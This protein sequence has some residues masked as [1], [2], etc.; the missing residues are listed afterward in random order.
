MNPLNCSLRLVVFGRTRKNEPKGF[1]HCEDSFFSEKFDSNNLSGPEKNDG[2]FSIKIFSTHS[3][4][5]QLLCD[6]C[7]TR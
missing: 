5:N 6:N 7:L 1:L 2:L 4:R 3:E